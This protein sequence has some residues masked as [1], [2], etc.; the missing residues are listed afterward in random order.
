M[1]FK[2][3]LTKMILL[4]KHLFGSITHTIYPVFNLIFQLFSALSELIQ[5]VLL[6]V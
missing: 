6:P 5:L 2:S 1:R 3:I 4:A